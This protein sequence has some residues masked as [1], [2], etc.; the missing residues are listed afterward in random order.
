MKKQK[1]DIRELVNKSEVVSMKQSPLESLLNKESVRRRFQEVLKDNAGSF[2]SSI[3]T[4]YN[5]NPALQQCDPASILSASMI[6]ATLKLPI[7]QSLGFAY[8]IPYKNKATFQIG[9]KGL[10]Q[11]AMRSGQYK[12]LNVCVVYEGQIKKMNQFTG[13]IEFDENGKK[14]DKVIGYLAYEKLINGF[15]KYIFISREDAEKHAQKYSQSYRKGYGVW[16]EDFDTMGMKT[17]MKQLLSKWGILSVEMQKAIEFDQAYI[18]EDEKP[19]YIDNG[20]DIVDAPVDAE[21][22]DSIENTEN[23]ES[24]EFKNPSEKG[25]E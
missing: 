12:T 5:T 6:S 7:N 25:N 10:V 3:L 17:A 19:V 16:I 23:V 18:T 4:A 14:S 11:L 13:E 20:Q 22:N 15:E 1:K 8:I 21:S 24:M 2:I 9:W